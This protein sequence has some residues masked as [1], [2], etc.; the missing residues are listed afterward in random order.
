[1]KIAVVCHRASAGGW[2]YV[3]MLLS[4]LK[5]CYPNWEISLFHAHDVTLDLFGFKEKF[6]EYGINVY[7]YPFNVKLHRRGG[8]VN[9]IWYPIRKTILKIRIWRANV[10]DK[11]KKHDVVFY[12]WPYGIEPFESVDKPAFFI[13]H[14]FIYTHWFGFH[15]GNLYNESFFRTNYDAHLKFCKIA[16]PIVSSHYIAA[17]F[18][19]TFPDSAQMPRVVYLSRF[20]EFE[21]IP[22]A[23][24]KQKLKKFGIDFPYLLWPSNW[25]YHKNIAPLLGAFYEVKQKYPDVKLILTGNNTK[26]QRVVCRSPFY[27]DHLKPGESDWDI[28][29]MGELPPDDF[30]VLLQG[31]TAVINTSLCEAGAGS[32]LDAWSMGIPMIMSDIEPFRQQV[33]YLGT[34]AEFFDPRNSHDVAKAILRVLDNLTDARKNAKKSEKAIAE[35][36]WA[37][38]ARQY[39]E[40]FMEKADEK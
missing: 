22:G 34:C 11:L 38:V 36:T 40:I 28:W 25:M 20:N 8:L 27:C 35:Y 3:F 1:M 21:K 10:A 14:D 30:A 31:A 12:A 19:N 29:G 6:I 5:R 2:N 37:D 32:A 39:A 9:K 33:E 7:H 15:C 16:T 23:K 24:L 26:N 17:E 18:K 13:P 4:N